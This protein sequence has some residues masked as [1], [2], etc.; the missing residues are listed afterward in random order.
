ME[1]KI[2]PCLP[3]WTPPILNEERY[4]SQW[5]HSALCHIGPTTGPPSANRDDLSAEMRGRLIKKYICSSF[6][7]VSGRV[8]GAQGCGISIRKRDSKSAASKCP[9]T[10]VFGQ[11]ACSFGDTIDSGT[12][13]DDSERDFGQREVCGKTG[14]ARGV[15]LS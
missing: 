7:T 6:V 13:K 4:H 12:C 15:L 3:S 14:V 8:R 9:Q 11:A 10:S 2:K 5:W 1:N